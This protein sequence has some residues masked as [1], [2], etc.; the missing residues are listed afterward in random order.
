MIGT[1]FDHVFRYFIRSLVKT[2]APDAICLVSD[3]FQ[4][5]VLVE[6]LTVTQQFVIMPEFLNFSAAKS[7]CHI[8]HP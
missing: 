8:T 1:F 4:F 5:E 7:E 6:L 3:L 2:V